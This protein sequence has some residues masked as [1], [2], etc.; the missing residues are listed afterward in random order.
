MNPP[1]PNV[2]PSAEN[3]PDAHQGDVA[4]TILQ[5]LGL[6]WRTFNPD[7]RPPLPLG[8]ARP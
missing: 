4:A 3:V 2:E 5:H 1:Q 8:Y 7:A 6:D